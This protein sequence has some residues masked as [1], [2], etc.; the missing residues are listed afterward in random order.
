MN[1][2]DKLTEAT[3]LALQG[4]LVE[5]KRLKTKL[6]EGA[7]DIYRDLKE[8][9]EYD[10]TDLFRAY[11]K[12]NDDLGCF[13]DE[14]NAWGPDWLDNICD[15]YDC[16]ESTAWN[17]TALLF[18]YVKRQYSNQNKNE[19]FLKQCEE[20]GKFNEE[21]LDEIRA[22]F[23]HRLSLSKVKSYDNHRLIVV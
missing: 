12:S 15:N 9:F 20:S 7:N 10:M 18:D 5:G 22:G 23:E 1:E 14:L 13:I 4:K 11:K 19:E 21:Q 17:A 2:K 16:Y 8:E 3:M 6:T